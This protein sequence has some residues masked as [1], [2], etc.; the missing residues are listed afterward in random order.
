MATKNARIDPQP[1]DISEEELGTLSPSE[2]RN[3]PGGT[4]SPDIV[5]FAEEMLRRGKAYAAQQ[6]QPTAPAPEAETR[7]LAALQ[8][9]Q[10]RMGQQRDESQSLDALR[11]DQQQTGQLRD[12]Q[13][14]LDAL[15]QTR[16]ANDNDPS[17]NNPSI[18]TDRAPEE[19]SRPTTALS[20]N[21]SSSQ[22]AR[23]GS[24]E[25]IQRDGR[26]ALFR[27]SE[28]PEHESGQ[29]QNIE[30][31]GRE[32]LFRPDAPAKD[33]QEQTQ[34]QEQSRERQMEIDR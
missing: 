27:A 18:Q 32:K 33:A 8:Q 26:E 1:Q 7:S 22:Q 20:I 34:T 4:S 23:Q 10:I 6:A 17:Q 16:A 30:R 9:D 31:D 11:Q 15:Q 5:E 25:I 24:E 14:S 2:G 28:Q 21:P 12:E 19:A 3:N 29:A 13:R